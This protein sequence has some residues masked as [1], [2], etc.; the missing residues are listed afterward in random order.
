MQRERQRRGIPELEQR[1]DQGAGG[2]REVT[3]VAV[4]P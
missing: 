3:K 2:Q 4:T 1:P